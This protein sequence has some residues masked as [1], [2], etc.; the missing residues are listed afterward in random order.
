MWLN[1]LEELVGRLRDRIHDH[2]S[3]LMSSESTTRYALVDPL[4]AG[5][6]WDLADPGQVLTEYEASYEGDDKRHYADYVLLH[7]KRPCLVIEAK[8]L[9]TK[10]GT[11][12]RID[13]GTKYC[14]RVGAQ[15]FVLTDGDRWE[16]RD[17]TDPRKPV[18]EFDVTESRTNIIELLW[19][20]PGNFYG[21]RATPVPKP[22][23][24]QPQER[25]SVAPSPPLAQSPTG[26]SGVPLPDVRYI[27][28]MNNPR[29]LVF[30]DGTTKD[31][32]K[33][34]ASVQPATA[35][36]L[37]DTNRVKSLP[38]RN[39]QGT[40]LLHKR[41]YRKDGKPFRRGSA[42]EVRKNHWIDMNFGPEGHLRKAKELLDSCDVEPNSVL[43][44]LD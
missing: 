40:H 22:R 4:L 6:G 14:N 34:W 31:V 7:G 5:L 17:R 42:K 44:E 2:R 9:G 13:Q 19:L 23:F 21:E 36:W 8:S 26:R 35:E 18:F 1:D 37:I 16:A 43:L 41:P 24:E 11:G 38:L 28:G 30:P 33:S 27:K 3:I 20:W 10:L 15:H 29:R 25:M 32:T 39:R 12:D